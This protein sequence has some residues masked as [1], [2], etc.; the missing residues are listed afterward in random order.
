MGSSWDSD[1]KRGAETPTHVVRVDLHPG[2]EG[3]DDR[4]ESRD[5]REPVLALQV[6]HVPRHDS[7]CEFNERDGDAELDRDHARQESEAL[8]A[9]L[10][11]RHSADLGTTPA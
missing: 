1:R 6:E 11:D 5:E 3:Q 8:R 10:R 2:E 4:R 9:A 7:E